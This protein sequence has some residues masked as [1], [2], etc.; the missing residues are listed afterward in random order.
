MYDYREAVKHDISEYIA[1]NYTAEELKETTSEAFADRIYDELWTADSVTGNASGSYTFNTYAAEDNLGHN[2]A[3]VVEAAEA[4]GLGK[5]YLD[6]GYEFGAEYW[7][8][9]IR[10]YLLSEMLGEVIEEL[11]DGGAFQ[12]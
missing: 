11:E 12:E 10:C 3:L 8:V 7:D 9:T 4:F 2:W 6:T 5:P 1:E